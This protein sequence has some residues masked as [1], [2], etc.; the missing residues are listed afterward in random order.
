MKIIKE[1]LRSII[2]DLD[3]WEA[4]GLNP[5]KGLILLGNVG[6]GKTTCMESLIELKHRKH[7]GSPL[8]G[9]YYSQREINGY[10]SYNEFQKGRSLDKY[11][12]FVDDIGDSG[13]SVVKN[14]GSV[15]SPVGD[16]IDDRSKLYKKESVWCHN[17][18]FNYFTSN[19]FMEDLKQMFGEQIED[20]LFGMCNI[21]IVTGESYRRQ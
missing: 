2:L 6:V 17:T 14:Y 21:V 4:N 8:K 3:N 11:Q 7:D 10:G 13:L 9:H 16:L 12:C 19:H 18:R 5:K 15:S 20:R 1:R